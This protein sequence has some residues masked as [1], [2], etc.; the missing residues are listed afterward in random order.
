[1]CVCARSYFSHGQLFAT[2]W[3]VACQVPSSM[4]FSSKSWSGLP[5]PPPGYLPDAGIKLESPASPVLAF[6][7]LLFVWTDSASGLFA[8]VAQEDPCAL[9]VAAQW[10]HQPSCPHVAESEK[11]EK[12]P[13][14]SGLFT[15]R[16]TWEAS[17]LY[18]FNKYTDLKISLLTSRWLRQ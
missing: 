14:A 17:R 12:S 9:H 16:A 2:L 8:P 13:S 1:M 15:H 5:C 3:V 6:W 7:C 18:I 4:G 11:C 10:S